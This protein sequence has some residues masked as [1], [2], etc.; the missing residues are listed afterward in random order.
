[1]IAERLQLAAIILGLPSVLAIGY[2]L[3]IEA[4]VSA[5][6]TGKPKWLP[7]YFYNNIT[8]NFKRRT[9]WQKKGFLARV[10]G[11]IG[12]LIGVVLQIAATQIQKGS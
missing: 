12:I 11:L 10:F 1:M 5:L 4:I 9:T 3:L 2:S 6:E 7:G 8:L